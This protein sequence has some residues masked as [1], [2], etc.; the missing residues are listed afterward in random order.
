MV[1]SRTQ[2]RTSMG[3]ALN[4][5]PRKPTAS[6]CLSGFVLEVCYVIKCLNMCKAIKRH[7][8]HNE[9]F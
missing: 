4:S 9:A 3:S 5:I 7:W 1:E 6:R 2:S 8:S